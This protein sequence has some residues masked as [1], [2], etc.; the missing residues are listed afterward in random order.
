MLFVAFRT[1]HADYITS[2]FGILRI[3]PLRSGH[4]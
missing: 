3:T 1:S 4:F 2:A